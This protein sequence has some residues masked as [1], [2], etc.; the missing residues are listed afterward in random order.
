MQFRIFSVSKTM[1][2]TTT[3]TRLGSSASFPMAAAV[4][5]EFFL[6]AIIAS[7]T[8]NIVP[9]VGALVAPSSKWG[10]RGG[11]SAKLPKNSAATTTTTTAIGYSLDVPDYVTLGLK[12]NSWYQ[13]ITEP[14]VRA[15]V[16][17]D[18]PTAYDDDFAFA[19][20][21]G[22]NWP[23]LINDDD[24]GEMEDVEDAPATVPTNNNRSTRSSSSLLSRV[25]GSVSP[26]RYVRRVLNCCFAHR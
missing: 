1:T 14:T 25:G 3:S 7:T 20:A 2:M 8:L 12:T 6:L 15:I 11:Y 23:E 4:T 13:E 18:V 5:A 17:D 21:V 26:I 22:S 9:L 16:Y 10:F 19:V 24:Y